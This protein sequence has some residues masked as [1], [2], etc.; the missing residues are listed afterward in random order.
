VQPEPTSNTNKVT[1]IISS[2]DEEETNKIL[3]EALKLG[4]PT[5]K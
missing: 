4:M 3:E 5:K 1:E 2:D